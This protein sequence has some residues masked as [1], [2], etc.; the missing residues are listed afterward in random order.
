M[1]HIDIRNQQVTVDG[2][3]TFTMSPNTTMTVNGATLTCDAH[4]MIS[5]S[6]SGDGSLSVRQVVDHIPPGANVVG[7][8]IGGDT[9][10]PRPP[11][12]PRA[13][14]VP[15]AP[16]I[17]QPRTEP[18][19]VNGAGQAKAAIEALFGSKPLTDAQLRLLE[20]QYPQLGRLDDESWL[21]LVEEM[22]A[23]QVMTTDGRDLEAIMRLS[24][25]ANRF[26][27]GE[28]FIRL[29]TDAVRFNTE[30]DPR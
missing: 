24:A 5:V 2:D 3:M 9:T 7:L 25:V 23:I 30:E 4:G 11:R 17:P 22:G 16:R 27:I 6:G 18:A 29:I 28:D 10:S 19:A 12:E 8:V 1:T 14:R 15:R 13:L 21:T 20:R 26:G